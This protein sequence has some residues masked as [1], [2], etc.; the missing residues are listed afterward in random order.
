M[1]SITST[2]EGTRASVAAALADYYVELRHADRATR[3]QHRFSIVRALTALRTG[4]V[5]AGFEREA[6]TALAAACGA[7]HE[8]L[9]PM[10]PWAGLVA[11]DL[12][13]GTGS[14]G[15][16][17]V[18]TTPTGAADALRGFSVA[19]DAGVTTL[20]GLHGNVSIPRV[21]TSA[22]AGALSSES[23]QASESTPVYGQH[24]LAPKHLS[25]YV[26]LSR[27]VDAQ[28]PAVEQH[29]RAHLSRI[30]GELLDKQTLYGS[31]AAGE[32]LGIQS[33][34]GITAQSG[35]AL[36]WAGV[37][38]MR[39]ACISAGADERRL[40]WI[41]AADTQ[42]VLSGRE[43][44]TGAGAI[45]A[46]N[47]IGGRPAYPTKV[48]QAGS[49]LVGD[50]SQVVLGLWGGGV[51]LEYNPYA[52]F[53]AGVKAARVVVVA[54]VALLNAAAFAVSTSVT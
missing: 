39:K 29:L 13:A 24:S 26:E 48:A 47:G 12:T 30:V 23:T 14:A 6:C 46:D 2:P 38:A 8:P 17:L 54:D 36:S 15:G 31:G 50:W 35:S 1:D 22:T 53:Q 42:E 34:S 52:N 41:A 7:Q 44:F 11:R 19:V 3:P 4:G 9:K 51:Q 45:W 18:P 37:R 32:I 33:A 5:V 28:V 21:G 25:G 40:A 27:L 49:L 43:R 10:I 20:D 16:Y